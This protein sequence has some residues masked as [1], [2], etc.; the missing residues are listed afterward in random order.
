MNDH[1]EKENILTFGKIKVD[2][3]NVPY[4]RIVI[5]SKI[6]NKTI[7]KENTTSEQINEMTEK[8]GCYLIRQPL[9]ILSR[10]YSLID[11]VKEYIKR[12]LIT[13]GYINKSNKEEYEEFQGWVYFALTGKKKE[14]LE[15]D[16]EIMK[17]SRKIYK[18][19]EAQNISQEQCLEL[20]QTLVVE[21]AKELKTSTQDHKK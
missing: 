12:L 2:V 15:T 16:S 1:N 3:S 11:S 21:Q 17:F 6:W 14:N 13:P 10:R 19:M 4:G 5:A 18:E 20:L 7:Q 8:V 9:E